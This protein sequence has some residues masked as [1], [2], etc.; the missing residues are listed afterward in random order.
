M[1]EIKRNNYTVCIDDAEIYVDNKS[2]NRSGHMSHAMAEFAPGKII[3]FNSN[4]SALRTCGHQPYGWIEYR[5][6]E[7]CGKSYS[8]IYELAY[9]VKSFQDGIHS[10]S[11]EK[12]VS[13]DDG[14]I[15]AFCL[16]NCAMDAGFCEP[17]SS[18]TLIKSCDGG[19]TWSEPIEWCP[20]AGRVYDARYYKGAIYVLIF[21]NE[22]HEG[23]LPEHQ[24]RIYKSTDGGNSF[25]WFLSILWGVPTVQ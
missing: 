19:K 9:S 4:C 16:R 13:T 12:A 7:D 21:C 17:W 5:I 24:Y 18:P 23:T 14:T 6:S 1:T 10:I 25:A 15:V 22:Q 8:D 11:V 20:Y 3:D 2:R